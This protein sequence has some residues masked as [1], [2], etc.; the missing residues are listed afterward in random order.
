M[1][2]PHPGPAGGGSTHSRR[3]SKSSNR[4]ERRASRGSQ[5]ASK[6]VPG[7]QMDVP[8]M[9]RPVVQNLTP[10]G[11][12]RS[13]GSRRGDPFG[14]APPIG[15]GESLDLAATIHREAAAWFRT[16]DK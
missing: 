15:N 11:S 6:G 12:A 1:P 2:P 4:G 3:G 9:E 10:L 16:A 14:A 7:L 5:P 13:G 8:R